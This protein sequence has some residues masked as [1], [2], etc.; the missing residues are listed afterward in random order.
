MGRFIN[1]DDMLGG[2][3]DI[4]SYNLFAYCSND[5]INHSDPS[6]TVVDLVFEAGV[7]AIVII[8]VGLIVIATA[9]ISLPASPSVAIPGSNDVLDGLRRSLG[10]VRDGIIEGIA[11]AKRGLKNLAKSIADDYVDARDID[12]N[13]RKAQY[14]SAIIVHNMVTPVDPLT[15]SEARDWIDRGGNLLCINRAAAFAII[16]FYSPAEYEG[17]HRGGICGYLN[18]YHLSSAHQNHIWFYGD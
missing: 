2:N 3:G 7:V 5:P 16:R 1:A 9:A 8:V 6:G 18:H 13:N 14:W 12:S 17:A 10:N 11:K 4:Q 15:Y